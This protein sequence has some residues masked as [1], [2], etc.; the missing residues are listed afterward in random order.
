MGF[1]LDVPPF[2]FLHQLQG[3]I[4]VK[5]HDTWYERTLLLSEILKI[6]LSILNK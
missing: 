5:F 4:L 1:S 6:C 3:C 2:T